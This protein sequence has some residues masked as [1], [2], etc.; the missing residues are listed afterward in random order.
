MAKILRAGKTSQPPRVVRP[1]NGQKRL[2]RLHGT[3]A[4]D[5]GTQIVAGH[6]KP[7]SLLTGEIIASDKLRVS[8]TA[9]REAVRTLAA[10]GLVDS[11]PKVGTRVTPQAKW[12][13]LDPDLLAWI[14][15]GEP[16]PTLLTNLFELRKIIEPEAA[17]LA[18]IRRTKQELVEMS[19][20]LTQMEIHTLTVEAGR[21][22]DQEFHSALLSAARNV[23][24]GSLTTGISAAI[25]WTTIF[26]QRQNALSRDAVPD[27]RRVY[28]AIAAGNSSAAH[29]AMYN[30]IDNALLD[31]RNVRVAKNKVKKKP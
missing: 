20:A 14:F 23:F 13:M 9:Y 27:H 28:D 24:L 6:F 1:H 29:K 15:E 22:A 18:A 16:N 17:A 26:K 31:T 21:I 25:T 2:L 11:R 4:R 10:K 12:H 7:G 8:R 19:A 3:I 5:L 30:L